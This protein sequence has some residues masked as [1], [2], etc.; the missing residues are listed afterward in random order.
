MSGV[1]S[2]TN[3]GR[4]V[5]TTRGLK[6]AAKLYADGQ[7]LTNPRLSPLFGSFIGFPP[8]LIVVG[9][10]DLLLDDARRLTARMRQ[11]GVAV[12]LREWPGCPHGFTG[13]PAPEGRDAAQRLDAFILDALPAAAR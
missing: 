6:A 12:Q 8:T 13:V 1:S 4:D 5:L 3:D 2:T 7:G 11:D 9:G 10:L